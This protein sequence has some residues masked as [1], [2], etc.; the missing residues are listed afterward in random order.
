LAKAG[1]SGKKQGAGTPVEVQATIDGLN[2]SLCDL[3]AGAWQGGFDVAVSWELKRTGAGSSS[4]RVRTH[5]VAAHQTGSRARPTSTGL[6]QALAAAVR[7]LFAQQST[8]AL[9]QPD[10]STARTRDSSA[11]AQVATAQPAS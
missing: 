8:Q 2:V 10:E 11:A 9:L 7:D 1:L 6:R 4:Y 5:G 3:G